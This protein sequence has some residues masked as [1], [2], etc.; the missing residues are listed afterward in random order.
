MSAPQGSPLWRPLGVIVRW[1]DNSAKLRDPVEGD[2]RKLDWLQ[3]VPYIAMHVACLGVFLVG[4][5]AFA[6]GTAI[7]LYL[8]RMF[9]ITGF[10]HRYFSHRSF[11]TSRAC[12]F[13]FAVLGNSAVQRGPLWWAAHHRKHHRHSDRD[14]DVHSPTREGFLWSHMLW[15]M[16]KG[17]FAT[18]EAVIKDFAKYGE[19]RWLDRFDLVVPLALA[20]GLFGL[21]ALLEA[22]APGLGTNGWQLLVWG[23][24]ISTV[25]VSHATYTINSLAHVFGRPRYRTRDTSKNNFVLAILTLGEGW[26]N[27]HHHYCASTRQGFF[28]W[29]VDLTYYTL[30]TMSKL[31]M[32]WDLKP[33]PAHAKYA[34]HDESAPV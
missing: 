17:N 8:I 28:W 26:H 32:V 31:G 2:D 18:D 14:G 5:S 15:F 16:A 33:V 25:A 29:E 20:V 12:Q 22:V 30:W 6:V 24:F 19:L 11:K 3:V 4:W 34:H 10:Y 27:N 13:L 9:A 7:A 23:F 1:F 21:G